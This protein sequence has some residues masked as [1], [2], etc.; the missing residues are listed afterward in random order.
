MEAIVNSTDAPSFCSRGLLL[1]LTIP[2]SFI[3]IG[4]KEGVLDAQNRSSDESVVI[5]CMSGPSE[6]I[7]PEETRNVSVHFLGAKNITPEIQIYLTHLREVTH[8]FTGN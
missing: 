7:S 6:T 2:V 1:S 3:G 4:S 5:S 8:V